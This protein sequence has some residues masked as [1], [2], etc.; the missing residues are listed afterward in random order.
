[1]SPS[2]TPLNQWALEEAGVTTPAV[3]PRSV[4]LQNLLPSQVMALGSGAL[5]GT[6]PQDGISAL[7]KTSETFTHFT[8]EA[9]EEVDALLTLMW[10]FGPC[11]TV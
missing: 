4:S 6:G 5:A 9:G 1:M 8:H 2:L 3:A 7:M 11:S 10:T